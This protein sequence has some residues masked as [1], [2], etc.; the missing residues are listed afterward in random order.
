MVSRIN[1]EQVACFWREAQ[2]S[3]VEELAPPAWSHFVL[4]IEGLECDAVFLR[5]RLQMSL[6][7]LVK[8]PLVVL[9]EMSEP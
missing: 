1:D 3:P 7:V 5:L 8:G 4:S 9:L 2:S 6:E